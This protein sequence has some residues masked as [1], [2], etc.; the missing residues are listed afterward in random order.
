MTP[1]ELKSARAALGLTQAEFA[2]AFQ[3]SPRAIG[4]WEQGT[5]NGRPHA[6]P[7]PLALLVGFALKHPAVR[8]ELGIRS[9]ATGHAD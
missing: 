9:N 6:I 3:I 8:R 7:A 1:E 4:G 2:K 5:R